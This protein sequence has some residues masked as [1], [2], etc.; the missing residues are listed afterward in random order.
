MKK[1]LL[2][3]L[4][5]LFSSIYFNAQ[6][7]LYSNTFSTSLGT[8]S[9]VA[10]SGGAWVFANA[11]SVSGSAGHTAPGHA[12]YQG[13]SCQF[14]NG[15]STVS[16]DL[17]I[18]P[19]PIGALGGTLTFNYFVLNECGTG[20]C[21]YDVLWLAI[22]NM[23]TN[24]TTTIMSS[25]TSPGGLSNTSQWTP[26][27]VNL[28]AY[29]GS[30]ISI[31]FQFNSGDGIGNAYDGI[32]LDD[33]N[34]LGACSINMSAVS[35]GNTVSPGLCSGQ[36]LTL[37]TNAV[38]GYSWS[39]GATTSSIVVNPSVT[40]SYSLTATSVSNCVSSAAI[41]VTVSG[42]LPTLSVNTS[43]N[44]VCLGRTVTL[45]A[46]GANTYSWTG[47]VTNGVSFTPT[48]TSTYVVTG[49]NGC[50]TATMATNVTV[51]PLAVSILASP[52]VVC[53][54]QQALLTVAAAATS[55][56][57]QPLNSTVSTNT[58]FV[59][60]QV[61]TTYSLA[62]G[63]G[64]CSGTATVL[65]AAIPIPTIGISASSTMVCQGD[66]VTLTATG[67]LSYTWT[68]VSSSSSVVTVNPL[69]PTLYSVSGSN[70]A[71][72]T[73]GSFVAV[74]TN[75]TPTLS[76]GS[77]NSII[78]NGDATTINVSGAS[79][80]TWSDGSNGTSITVTPNTTTV[81]AVSG[82]S[83]GCTSTESY[84]IDVFTP[85][86]IIAGNTTICSGKS[87]TLTAS[88]ANTYSWS[89]GIPSN[90]N[91]VNP[92]NNTTYTLITLT[93]TSGINCSASKT[94]QVSVNQNPTVTASASRTVMCRGENNVITANGAT[95]Y[96]WNTAA[97]TASFAITP[98][99]V[100][101][102]NY[103]VTGI[104]A[105]GCQ[106]TA[107][108]SL[109]VNSCTDINETISHSSSLQLFPNPNNGEFNLVGSSQMNLLIINQLGQIIKTVELNSANAFQTKISGLSSGIYFVKEENKQ[110]GT[111]SKIIVNN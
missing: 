74:I 90:V 77:L 79:T 44:N 75:P 107:T 86:I 23:S 88:G 89:N 87:A 80:Y 6:T 93:S 67:G 4:T 3:T 70:A 33:I 111:V 71:G 57:W 25:N 73:S 5:I 22:T 19:I 43:S 61:N 94:V 7:I 78:C 66:A 10:S 39:N 26:I 28:A 49:G 81:Y 46:T 32:Y 68:P 63:D 36:S 104:G 97:T 8:A 59:S 108:L 95:T 69:A 48:T 85:N 42:G 53:S 35:G 52:T 65:V 72:C 18:P 82:S 96:S 64:T 31:K 24:V 37:T 105:N 84:T 16:G 100:T 76:L 20:S 13:S 83:N 34:V 99:L 15:S 55:Y 50:G 21:S 30:T 47:G 14:G 62:A 29:A 41:T 40:T 98:S 1:N 11:C 60:P 106:N 109:K 56:S 103:S 91:I 110:N 45:T 2:L 12:L 101:T 27:S 38:S 92:T 9:A 17:I 102:I 58:I 54:G 51:A